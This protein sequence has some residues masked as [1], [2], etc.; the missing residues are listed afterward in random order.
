MYEIQYGSKKITFELVFAERKTLE[1]SVLP[2]QSVFVKAPRGKP[3]EEVLSRVQKRARWILKQKLYFSSFQS[4]APQKEYV[5]GETFHYLGRQYR[6]KVIQL[7]PNGEAAC[8]EDVKLQGKYFNIYTVSK[9]DRRKVK[10]LLDGWYRKHADQKL[11]QRLD[12]CTRIMQK[13][14]IERPLMEIRIMKNRWGSFTPSGKILLNPKLIEWPTYCIDY[15]ILHELCHLKHPNH[16]KD[17]YRLLSAVL[18]EWREIK[19][20]LV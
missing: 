12:I 19:S 11:N 3:L 5:S 4:A 6:L 14:G 13:Y 1:I 2:D 9:H 18:P 10:N 16:S 8:N 20:R 7:N 15:V 17:F